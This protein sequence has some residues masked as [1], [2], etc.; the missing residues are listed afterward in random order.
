MTDKKEADWSF[1]I[2][3]LY[4]FHPPALETEQS[5][6]TALKKYFTSIGYLQVEPVGQ[7]NKYYE[8][9][10][11]KNYFTEDRDFE[12]DLATFVREIKKLAPRS[13]SDYLRVIRRVFSTFGLTP[14]K[15]EPDNGHKIDRQVWRD[16]FNFKAY[17]RT[18]SSLPK[19]KELRRI[20][21]HSD[22]LEGAVIEIAAT[23][24]MRIGEILK[25]RLDDI[26]LNHHPVSIFI[27]P[28]HTK[29]RKA[30]TAYITDEAAEYLE[31][32]L[33]DREDYLE[34]KR[35]F[36]YTNRKDEM[37]RVF[38]IHSAT[39]N[40]RYTKLLERAGL[41][42]RSHTRHKHH[43]HTLRAYFKVHCG[44]EPW[45]R[46]LIAGWSDGVSDTYSLMFDEDDGRRYLESQSNLF[47]MNSTDARTI[48]EVERNKSEVAELRAKV[49][50]L[51]KLLEKEMVEKT[52][53]E[54]NTTR[55]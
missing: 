51:T 5:I 18:Q 19:T 9:N 52:M 43:F 29:M 45:Y 20:V 17:K 41:A 25:I 31:R 6:I 40:Q 54:I 50:V 14:Q 32:W 1:I 42:E 26:N 7:Y 24:G 10:D 36:L 8:I 38:P 49:D 34:K 47:I 15:D 55:F 21:A 3:K 23:S 2:R 27:P 28:E 53:T 39:M 37:H 44:L 35:N 11:L 16:V 13:Q 30:R 12:K 46:N 4:R 22:L 33:D 48:E